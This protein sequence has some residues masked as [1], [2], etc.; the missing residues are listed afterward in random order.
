MQKPAND[1]D[2]SMEQKILEKS[3]HVTFVFIDILKYRIDFP[4]GMRGFEF[5]ENEKFML[6]YEAVSEKVILHICQFPV[7]EVCDFLDNPF[8]E[9]QIYARKKFVATLVHAR[10]L[11]D[12]GM[13]VWRHLVS[14]RM[15][16]VRVVPAFGANHVVR[17]SERLL[18][19][20]ADFDD[21]LLPTAM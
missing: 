4:A 16:C 18:A 5:F 2:G 6:F 9:F 21:F 14:L 8:F 13:A 11:Y 17:I 1:G 15:L 10:V 3:V 19:D 20:L 7:V 12:A